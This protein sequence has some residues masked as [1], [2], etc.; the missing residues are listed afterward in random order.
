VA[1]IGTGASTIQFLPSVQKSAGHVTLFQRTPPWVFPHR[2]RP[3]TGVERLA[4][5]V[6]PWTQRVSRARN[7]WMGEGLLGRLLITNSPKLVRIE[8]LARR[9]LDR[10]VADPVLQT[11]PAVQRLLPRPAATQRQRRDGEDH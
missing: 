4:F 9:L 11:A 3:T 5:R 7:Y 10:Q 2:N 8:K 1:I 6:L